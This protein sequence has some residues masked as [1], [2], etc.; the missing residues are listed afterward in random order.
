MIFKKLFSKENKKD[1]LIDV[2]LADEEFN[3]LK[4]R[5]SVGRVTV[6]QG[7]Q[8]AVNF[9]GI[10]HHLPVLQL[11]D[12]KLYIKQKINLMELGEK[13]QASL[14]V[15]IPKDTTLDGLEIQTI[16]AISK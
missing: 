10:R 14:Q 15:T 1:E 8:F 12:E 2:E 9:T 13:C 16:T 6:E 5:L 4:I 3:A 7:E 11:E